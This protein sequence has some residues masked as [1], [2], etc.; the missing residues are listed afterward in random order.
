MSPPYRRSRR[1]RSMRARPAMPSECLRS[2][3]S[4]TGRGAK[5][6]ERE[7]WEEGRSGRGFWG[8]ASE[9]SIVDE[10]EVT[11]LDADGVGEGPRQLPLSDGGL[12]GADACSSCRSWSCGTDMADGGVEV[13]A[14][15]STKK[16]FERRLARR[17]NQG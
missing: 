7:D 10:T 4:V 16:K 9:R 8:C 15:G 13:D 14:D 2:R 3:C 5:T 6:T 12:E 11:E 1:S 17:T